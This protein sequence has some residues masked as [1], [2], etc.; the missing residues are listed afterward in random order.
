MHVSPFMKG[1]ASLT[2]LLTVQF[3][4]ND[5]N[6]DPCL[7]DPNKDSKNKIKVHIPTPLAATLCSFEFRITVY[8]L[9][10]GQFFTFSNPGLRVR[11]AVNVRRLVVLWMWVRRLSWNEQERQV[12][13]QDS[14]TSVTDQTVTFRGADRNSLCC[15]L[16]IL[17]DKP[18]CK[19]GLVS[20]A[21]PA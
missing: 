9:F 8:K 1:L 7:S 18:K 21:S 6:S 4:S 19:G 12:D 10:K 14:E 11:V 16:G 13:K 15:L 17:S 3:V 5:L 2:L 20:P